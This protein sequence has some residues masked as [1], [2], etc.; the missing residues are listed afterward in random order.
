MGARN[1]PGAAAGRMGVRGGLGAPA[2]AGPRPREPRRPRPRAPAGP[3]RALP[4]RSARFR[5]LEARRTSTTSSPRW[6]RAPRRR[7][8]PAGPPPPRAVA[9]VRRV[10]GRRRRLRA[11]W[12]RR[13]GAMASPR[14][15]A[16]GRRSPR[17]RRAPPP[18]GPPAPPP[19]PPQANALLNQVSGG[20]APGTQSPGVQSSIDELE[21]LG[22]VCDESGCVL[23]LPNEMSD[24]EGEGGGRFRFGRGLCPRPG[25]R[26]IGRSPGSALERGGGGQGAEGRAVAGAPAGPHTC[27]PLLSTPAPGANTLNSYIEG[28]GWGLGMLE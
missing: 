20:A 14:H 15:A 22:Y 25:S 26:V 13:P 21:A 12:R 17:G 7:R 8:R 28:R 19:P 9:P 6:A 16:A 3:D 4:P 24:D 5:R 18:T 27:A 11:A 23:V 2:S 1:A 10:H